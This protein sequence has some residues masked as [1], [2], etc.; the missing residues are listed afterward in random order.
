MRTSGIWKYLP[1]VHELVGLPCPQDDV[2][3]LFEDRTRLVDRHAEHPVLR[4]LVSPSDADLDPSTREVIEDRD[5]LG[6]AKRVREREV[7]DGGPHVHTLRVRSH[8]P[9]EQ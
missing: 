8:D 2:E 7:H 6:E 3:R 9:G 4:E 5:A 1:V